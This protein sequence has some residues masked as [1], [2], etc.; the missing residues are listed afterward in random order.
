VHAVDAVGVRWE[1]GMGQALDR[2]CSTTYSAQAPR[3]SLEIVATDR[4]ALITAV[5][6]KMSPLPAWRNASSNAGLDNRASFLAA[7]SNLC[8]F[9][10]ATVF[11]FI[12]KFLNTFFF[13]FITFQNVQT[14][15]Q[16]SIV[17]AKTHV[18]IKR[19]TPNRRMLPSKAP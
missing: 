1:I 12:Q 14:F 7:C 4:G 2:S 11:T 17:V 19:L 10:I 9:P 18:Y 6:L 13:C 5:I 3:R 15:N 16:N 8:S